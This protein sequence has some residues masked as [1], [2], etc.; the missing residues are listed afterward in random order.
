MAIVGM[1]LT[2]RI[3]DSYSLKDKRSVI[4]SIIRRMHNKFNISIAEIDKQDMLNQSVIGISVVANEYQ[5][6]HTVLDKV[7][8]EIEETYAIDIYEIERM[9]T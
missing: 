5:Q 6:C 2:F 7:L 3:D 8:D 1:K 9:E 4:K